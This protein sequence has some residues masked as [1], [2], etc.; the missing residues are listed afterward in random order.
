MTFGIQTENC[1]FLKAKLVIFFFQNQSPYNQAPYTQPSSISPVI[2]FAPAMPSAGAFPDTFC[3]FLSSS[4][5]LHR[6]FTNHDW[7]SQH[8]SSR[9]LGE[10]YLLFSGVF[11]VELMCAFNSLR[12]HELQP[13]R[14]LCPWNFPGKTTGVGC[15]FL[16]QG[17]FPTQASNLCLLH[18]LRWQ[19]FTTST[20]SS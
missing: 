10:C 13:A 12:S 11:S 19:V 20:T 3:S 9:Q 7:S 5:T 1:L 17:I 4:P 15:H 18:L 2:Q 6:C 14:L 16:L 8:L